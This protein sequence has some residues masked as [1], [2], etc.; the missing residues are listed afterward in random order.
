[1]TI[2]PK[3]WSTNANS[4]SAAC[5]DRGTSLPRFRMI[6]LIWQ[7]ISFFVLF[8]WCCMVRLFC[9]GCLSYMTQNWN[10][11]WI[12]IATFNPR[13]QPATMQNV[14]TTRSQTFTL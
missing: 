4:S 11:I 10:A 13:L 3:K 8:I 14:R 2:S 1:M 6:D 5:N 12:T 7:P 9:M